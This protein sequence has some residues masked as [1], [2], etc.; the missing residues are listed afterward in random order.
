[1]SVALASQIEH[2]RIGIEEREQ[3]ARGL[4][5]GVLG[6]RLRQVAQIPHLPLALR[7]AV[8]AGG[9]HVRTIAQ[10]GHLGAFRAV[11]RTPL[12]HD[13]VL[14]RIVD[15]VH[16]ILRGKTE[17]TAVVVPMQVL[18]KAFAREGH[19]LAPFLAVPHLR[20]AVAKGIST[21]QKKEYADAETAINSATGLNSTKVTFL[22]CPVSVKIGS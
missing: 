9:E 19:Q 1:M 6:D 21:K 14:A 15:G 12:R 8:E 13:A 10:P 5:Q 20:G 18:R 2:R 7:G 22:R 17:Q 16:L 4:I 11:V 3:R